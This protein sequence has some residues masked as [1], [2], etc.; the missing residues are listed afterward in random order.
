MQYQTFLPFPYSFGA[1]FNFFNSLSNFLRLGP[2]F[3]RI[4]KGVSNFSK[5]VQA[6]LA[7]ASVALSKP[8]IM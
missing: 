8:M 4:V 5:K 2:S 3:Q 6:F 7:S 1:S